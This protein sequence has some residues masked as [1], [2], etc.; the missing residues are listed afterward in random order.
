MEP[1]ETT[2][3]TAVA[4]QAEPGSA[5]A[6]ARPSSIPWST[7]T[8]PARLV[9][10]A[11]AALIGIWLVIALRDLLIQVLIATIL[12]AGI[13]PLTVRL[14]RIGLPRGVSVILIYLLLI[15]ALVG[16]GFL[17]VPPVITEVQSLITQAPEFGAHFVAS[18]DSLQKQFT[19]LPPLGPALQDQVKN[20]GNQA[21]AIL[22]QALNLIGIALGVF[23]GLLTTILTLLITF[24]LVVDGNRIRDYLLSFLP[25]S[26]IERARR[27]TDTIGTRM[28]GWLIGQIVLSASIGIA[29]FIA[30]TLI[31]VHN[32]LLLS[33]VAGVAELIPL[34]G[35]W[36]AAVPA[37]AVAFTQSPLTALLT[38]IAYVIIQQ[39]E[40]NL[41]AP[42]IM[43]RA[44]RLHPL[45]VILA[46]LAGASLFGVIGA[47]IAVP[48]AAAVSV[49]LDEAR[50]TRATKPVNAADPL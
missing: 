23:G 7:W 17:L 12:A 19:F 37:V 20:L 9:I 39:L 24:Y 11:L 3:D 27:V 35:P 50:A 34:L 8:T 49:L 10:L 44:V 22:A 43:S 13:T 40:S 41:L 4:V 30:L 47:L 5:T 36:I 21:G 29:S 33:V 16:L 28:G 15:L 42:R 31:G 45:G 1:T 26:Q 14:T 2:T 38:I 6:P 25:A 48:V 32:A 46:L 18:L